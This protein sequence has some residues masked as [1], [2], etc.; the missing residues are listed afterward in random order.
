MSS[1]NS[2]RMV[3]EKRALYLYDQACKKNFLRQFVSVLK[4]EKNDLLDLHIAG[5]HA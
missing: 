4:R 3:A 1:L 5:G 2:N